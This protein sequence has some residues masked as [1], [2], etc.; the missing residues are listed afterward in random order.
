MRHP[1][2]IGTSTRTPAVRWGDGRTSLEP[3]AAGQQ[4]V[5]LPHVRRVP[6]MR[7]T[8]GLPQLAN[9]GKDLLESARSLQDD[10]VELRLTPGDSVTSPL[11]AERASS[12]S[13][14]A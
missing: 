10:T 7:K 6:P 11:P 4:S 13:R 2:G 8:W 3:G 9:I 1:I 12:R 14:A 5:P